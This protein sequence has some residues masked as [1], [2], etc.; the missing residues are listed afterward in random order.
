MNTL[1]VLTY[2]EFISA[3]PEYKPFLSNSTVKGMC[4]YVPAPDRM[5]VPYRLLTC[6]K[7]GYEHLYAYYFSLQIQGNGQWFTRWYTEEEAWLI[8]D[9]FRHIGEIDEAKA[10]ALCLWFA[11]SA[12]FGY[13]T[14]RIDDMRREGITSIT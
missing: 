3:Y 2:E 12:P 5:R 13:T 4:L 8:V 11:N 9:L 10:Q 7:A 6:C 14:S 1:D